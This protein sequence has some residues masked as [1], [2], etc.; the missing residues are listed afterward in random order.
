MT[1]GHQPQIYMCVYVWRLVTGDT[2]AASSDLDKKN[3]FFII[4]C[5]AASMKHRAENTNG[6]DSVK[7]W[8]VGVR[9]S[10]LFVYLPDEVRC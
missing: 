1:D 5:G 7:T 9:V 10:C 2:H 4:R 3:F 8:S 6:I